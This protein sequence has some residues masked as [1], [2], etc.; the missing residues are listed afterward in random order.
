[1]A[2]LISG[3]HNYCDRWC[4]RC[5]FT[6]RCAVG[7]EETK[8]TDKER[9]ITNKEFWNSLHA[10]LR[11]GCQTCPTIRCRQYDD[12]LAEGCTCA[13]NDQVEI[14]ADARTIDRFWK[15]T[16]PARFAGRDHRQHVRPCHRLCARFRRNG[17]GEDGSTDSDSCGQH[18][19]FEEIRG[20]GELIALLGFQ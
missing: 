4:E 9:D 13:K 10:S 6:T 14:M 7:I 17:V 2:K 15:N 18:I 16:L 12:V 3:I 20:C 1:M 8:I 19:S 11:S 5:T